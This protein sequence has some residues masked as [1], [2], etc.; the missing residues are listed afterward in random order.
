MPQDANTTYDAVAD[1]LVT[2]GAT[3]ARMFGMPSLKIGG[4]A[5][6]GYS[7]GALVVKLRGEAHAQALA[8][9][10]ATLFDPMGGR[11]MKEWVVI[12]PEHA[13]RW[14]EF[15]HMALAT[16]ATAQS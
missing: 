1:D 5:F 4:K 13:D 11:P 16:M 3:R 7:Q 8:L 9:A 10:G 6:A 14:A 15:G 2:A 12:P